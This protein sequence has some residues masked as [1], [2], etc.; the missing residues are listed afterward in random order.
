MAGIGVL[1]SMDANGLQTGLKD[2]SGLLMYANQNT[3]GQSGLTGSQTLSGLGMTFG[4]TSQSALL[5]G[6][7]WGYQQSYVNQTNALQA[8]T[9]DMQGEQLG[10]NRQSTYRSWGV[11]DQTNTT[12]WNAQQAGFQWQNTMLDTNNR[13]RLEDAALTRNQREAT[14]SNNSWMRDFDYQSSLMKRDWSREDYQY[15]TQSREL[16]Y[17]WNMEDMDEQIRRSSGY[18]RAQLIKQRDRATVSENMQSGQAEKQFG[19]QE[20]MWQREDE[21]Y[22]KGVEYAD[23]MIELDT[24]RF[25]LNQKQADE[26]YQMQKEHL[27]EEMETAEK[28]HDLRMEMEALQ[29]ERQ[30]EQMDYQEKALDI[31]RQHT[32]LQNEYQDNMTIISHTQAEMEASL[33][34]ITNYSPAFSRMLGD[35]LNFLESASQIDVST[36]T[37][38][39]IY[40]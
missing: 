17:G 14:N 1:Q 12:Q 34:K 26:M 30:E 37:G 38:G 7:L 8:Q 40:R 25:E 27:G 35:F 24:A 31:Q 18:E 16:S 3:L 5:S 39:R 6:G 33:R 19:R 2:M 13:F 10:Y 23:Q 22:K 9:L 15:N 32:A 29:R 11:E 21:R 36:T 4:S 28:L 20:E